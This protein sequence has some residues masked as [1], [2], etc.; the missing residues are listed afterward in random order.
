[1]KPEDQQ[2]AIAEFVG[3]REAFPKDQSPHPETKRGGILLPYYWVNERTH[4]RV[5]KLPDFLNDSNAMRD[6]LI[7]LHPDLWPLFITN[8]LNIEVGQCDGWVSPDPLSKNECFP[9]LLSHPTM[10]AKTLLKVIQ[11]WT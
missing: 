11:K 8:L 1:M 7:Q 9:L 5:M 6:A 10:L 2:R 3:W 4:E